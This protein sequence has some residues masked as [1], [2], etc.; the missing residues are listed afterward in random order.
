MKIFVY[1]TVLLALAG[2][3]Y[4]GCNCLEPFYKDKMDLLTRYT[5]CLERCFV[6]KMDALE[7]LLNKSEARII[8]LDSEVDRLNERIK[9]L[10]DSLSSNKK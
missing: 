4:A 5:A 7:T 8:E 9:Q 6:T 3:G 2:N 10:E 1:L